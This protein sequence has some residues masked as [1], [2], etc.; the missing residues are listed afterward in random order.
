MKFLHN[1]PSHL[2]GIY[3]NFLLFISSFFCMHSLISKFSSAAFR[4]R[5]A[6]PPVLVEQLKLWAEA[7][8]YFLALLLSS[9]VKHIPQD[10]THEFIIW[11]LNLLVV[12]DSSLHISACVMSHEFTHKAVTKFLPAQFPWIWCKCLLPLL[13]FN[14]LPIQRTI[15]ID[16]KTQNRKLVPSLKGYLRL[17]INKN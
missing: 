3:I 4:T 8:M 6:L 13:H 5:R 10:A 16:R 12:V 14:S 15:S 17:T 9:Q 7:Y 2:V 11:K 1:L